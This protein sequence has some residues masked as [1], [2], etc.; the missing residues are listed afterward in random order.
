MKSSQ[1]TDIHLTEKKTF[2][3]GLAYHEVALIKRMRL[4]EYPRDYIFSF[5]LRP[6][7]KLT[8]ACIAEIENGQIGP[9]VEPATDREVEVFI[10][11]RLAET[12]DGQEFYGPLSSFQIN[13][14]LGWYT[15]AQ[16]DLFRDETQQ[17]EFKITLG[18]SSDDLHKYA[19]TMSAFANNVGGYIFVGVTNERRVVGID[20][21]DF[22]KFDWDRLANICREYFQPDIIWDRGLGSWGGNSL[23]VIYTYQAKLKPVVATK[24][25]KNMSAG[26][27]YYRYR[28]HTENIGVGDLFNL[29]A[30]RDRQGF[31]APGH[32]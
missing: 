12:S 27:I 5:I 15:R 31:S 26:G 16:G 1:N 4:M 9:D 22:M 28:G 20:E 2:A 13:E 7:R 19:K 24:S 8:P 29:L 14:A 32:N 17:V 10:A 25:T 3:R 30:E 23:G 21:N 11:M 18:S 6:G